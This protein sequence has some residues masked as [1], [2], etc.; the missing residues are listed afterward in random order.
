MSVRGKVEKRHK[1]K[2]SG[3]FGP[4]VLSGSVAVFN[5]SMFFSF[6]LACTLV[7]QK[8]VFFTSAFI[9]VF[10]AVLAVCFFF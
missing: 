6:C 8:N 9:V 1:K 3:E 2:A 10:V 5:V 7:I 4:F